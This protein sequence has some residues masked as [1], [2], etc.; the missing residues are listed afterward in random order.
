MTQTNWGR[1]IGDVVGRF[2]VGEVVDRR[3]RDAERREQFGH[4]NHTRIRAGVEGGLH[5]LAF[6]R[7]NQNES[8]HKKS[9]QMHGGG[10]D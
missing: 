9:L 5:F 8:E 3:L 6:Q 7:I 10:P 2:R 1:E 4:A